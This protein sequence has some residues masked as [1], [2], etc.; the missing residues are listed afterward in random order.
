MQ[1]VW[2]PRRC[3]S[4]THSYNSSRS[5][6][7]CVLVNCDQLA[8]DNLVLCHVGA[9]LCRELGYLKLANN[10][11]IV[12]I[13]LGAGGEIDLGFVKRSLKMIGC[14]VGGQ[15]LAVDGAVLDIQSHFLWLSST[16]SVRADMDRQRAAIADLSAMGVFG[17]SGQLIL[18][19]RG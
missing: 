5:I 1:I 18:T 4:C 16:L 13:A 15:L 19:S 6:A 14:I 17:P 2:A 8:A 10:L 11:A 3:A 12:L 9:A 7:N